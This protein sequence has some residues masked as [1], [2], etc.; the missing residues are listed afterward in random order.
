MG[1]STISENQLTIT[2]PKM[3]EIKTGFRNVPI[4]F[5]QEK[6]EDNRKKIVHE[7]EQNA[8]LGRK[9]SQLGLNTVKLTNTMKNLLNI[10]KNLLLK[11]T[12]VTEFLALGMD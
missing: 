2:A 9:L 8:R 10:M 3:T 5:S 4:V 1:T 6:I 12:E 7:K 11:V